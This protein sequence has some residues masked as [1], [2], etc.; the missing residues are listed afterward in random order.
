MDYNFKKFEGFGTKTDNRI[1]ITR[2]NSIGLPKKFHSD[3]KIKKYKH[4][5]L[6]WDRQNEAVGIL[7]TNDEQ[8]K[9]KFSIMHSDKYGGS[10]AAVSFFKKCDIDPKIYYGKYDWKKENIEGVGELFVINLKKK[11]ESD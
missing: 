7:F 2:S 3:N 8:E 5:V 10:I 4:A 11:V 1:T 9:H 6:Y